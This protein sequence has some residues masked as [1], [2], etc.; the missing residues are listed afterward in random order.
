MDIVRSELE[1]IQ[2]AIWLES[3]LGKGTRAILRVPLTIASVKVLIVEANGY[4]F[5]IPMSGV[6]EILKI[7][8]DAPRKRRDM[9]WRE[10]AIPLE[11]IA[12]ALN[13]PS[14]ASPNPKPRSRDA[15]RHAPTVVVDESSGRPVGYVVERVENAEEVVIKRL[16][17]PLGKLRS[18]AGAALLPSGEVLVVLEM[19]ELAF[20]LSKRAEGSR[21]ARVTE[22]GGKRRKRILLVEDSAT[23]R[24]LER[25][26]LE[27]EGYE[28]E[29]AVDGLEG[30]EKVSS[31]SF[32]LVVSDVEMPRMDGISFCKAM[33]KNPAV[34]DLPFVFVTTLDDPAAKLRGL[35]AG[36]QAYFSKTGFNQRALLET[37]ARLME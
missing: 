26:I 15:V 11:W 36:A 32:D 33:R 8:A 2:G 23:T 9:E 30:L 18:V 13:L 28:V 1:R 16:E 24:K 21:V 22:N 10:R 12:D 4:R 29:T 37:I 14:K 35:E 20:A 31:G 17:N 3:E 34:Q 6:A 25:Q 7:A 27:S 19:A 5:G